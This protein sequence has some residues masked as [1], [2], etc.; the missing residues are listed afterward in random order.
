M[1]A[2]RNGQIDAILVTDLS[3]LS[4]SVKDAV[5]LITDLSDRNIR[6]ICVNQG[7]TF[8]RSAMSQFMLHVFAALAELESS[9]KSER[10]KAGLAASDKRPG[11]PRNLE[12][13]NEIKRLRSKG[14]TITEIAA[15]MKMTPQGVYY[16]LR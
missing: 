13:R 12:K 11:R 3:R 1:D 2:C 10:I 14:K 8:D 15:A 4:R 7:L 16:L 5:S 9:I 6:L